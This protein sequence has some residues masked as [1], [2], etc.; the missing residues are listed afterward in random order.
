MFA[1]INITDENKDT[2][3]DVAVHCGNYKVLPCF[4]PLTPSIGDVS[5]AP[6]TSASALNALV[7][8]VDQ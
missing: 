1:D 4:A 7:D 8:G 3:T 5:M 6:V 2:A